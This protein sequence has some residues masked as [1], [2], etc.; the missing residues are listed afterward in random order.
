[1]SSVHGG[2][3]PHPA[4]GP[5][6]WKQ[7]TVVRLSGW[8]LMAEVQTRVRRRE[9]LSPDVVIESDEDA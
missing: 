5:D 4:G 9:H 3:E 7:G 2:G 6:A 8:A 1:M